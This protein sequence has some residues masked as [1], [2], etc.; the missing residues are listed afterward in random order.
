VSPLAIRHF[1]ENVGAV[2][3]CVFVFVVVTVVIGAC[4]AVCAVSDVLD[5]VN[6]MENNDK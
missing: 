4:I 2:G 6:M 3:A 1:L 5:A